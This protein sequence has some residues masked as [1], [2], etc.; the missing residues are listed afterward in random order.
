MLALMRQQRRRVMALW[1]G[2]AQV[3]CA[4]M[5]RRRCSAMIRR[6]IYMICLYDMI[7]YYA[8]DLPLM[9]PR[10]FTR[11]YAAQGH[12]MLLDIALR[13]VIAA[14]RWRAAYDAA[15]EMLRPA[16]TLLDAD[17]RQRKQIIYADADVTTVTCY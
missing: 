10:Y 14:C 1:R 3:I 8:A 6:A 4:L 9:L 11:C 12:G 5:L 2:A 16:A 13:Y 17:T 15:A 7:R